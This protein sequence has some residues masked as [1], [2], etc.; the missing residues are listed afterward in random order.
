MCLY[1]FYEILRFFLSKFHNFLILILIN[2]Y[3]KCLMYILYKNCS[4]N[5]MFTYL[6]RLFYVKY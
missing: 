3:I 4:Q 6:P 2:T 1:I 5:H